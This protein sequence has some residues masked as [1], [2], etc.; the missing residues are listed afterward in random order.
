MSESSEML[1][2]LLL[3]RVEIV[4]VELRSLLG[5]LGLPHLLLLF[6]HVSQ[7]H[8]ILLRH[9]AQRTISTESL[10]DKYVVLAAGLELSDQ[11]RSLNLVSLRLFTV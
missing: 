1:L 2:R 6:A 7:P 10:I 11:L 9:L 8:L 3:V 5:H 4:Q